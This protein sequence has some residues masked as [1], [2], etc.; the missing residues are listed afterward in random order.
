MNAATQTLKREIPNVG[1]GVSTGILLYLLLF[2][3]TGSIAAANWSDDLGTLTFAAAGSVTLA[4]ALAKQKRIPGWLAHLC[5]LLL[6]LPAIFYL[7]M[8]TLP[9]ALTEEEKAI[10][11]GERV[12]VWLS[13]VALG[14]SATDNLIFVLQLCWTMWLIAHF[15]GWSI[16]RRHQVWGALV[17]TG[18]A[19]VVNLFYSAPQSG[20]YIALYILC[21]L[22][23]LVRLNLQ[24]LEIDW[25][26]GAVGYSSDISFDFLWNGAIITLILLAVVWVIPAGPPSPAWLEFLEP[27]QSSW[28]GFEEQFNRMF[29]GLRGGGRSTAGGFFSNTLTMGGPI[30]LPQQ[31]VM[32]VQTLYAR[33]WR[34]NV[35]DKYNGTGWVNTSVDLLNLAAN[36]ARL[37]SRRDFLRAEV[38]QT[39]KLLASDLPTLFAQSQPIR[40]DLPVEV[41]YTRIDESDQPFVT[42]EVTAVRAR[43]LVR[44]GTVY[45][46]VSVI[47]VADEESLR[48]DSLDYPHW[49]TSTYLQ[50]PDT[51][52]TRVRE[53]AQSLTISY[54]NP[55]DKAVALEK[56]VR[57][58]IKYNEQVSAP[59]PDQDGVDYTL[60]ERREG[61]CNYYASSLAV[62]A[63]AV[64]IPARVVS[65]YSLGDYDNGTFHIFETNAHSWVEIYFPSYGWIEFEPT[66]NKPEFERPKRQTSSAPVEP[67]LEDAASEA[68]RRQAREKELEDE[69]IGNFDPGAFRFDFWNSPNAAAIIGGGIA[70]LIAL[71]TL[72]INI[73]KEIRRNARLAPAARVYERML[74]RARWLGLREEK[75]ATPLERACVINA[76]LPNAHIETERIAA[77]YTRERFG[78]H[79]LDEAERAELA[80]DWRTW[81]GEWL[82]GVRARIIERIVA[83]FRALTENAR[84]FKRRW[85][86]MG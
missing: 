67:E 2:S 52:P 18:V 76:T 9:S 20:L 77:S 30:N 33:Y 44:A 79:T 8:T 66:A 85:E 73:V 29:G 28:Q 57:N 65:G 3:V 32:N 5:S 21:A 78:A 54:T 17:P 12:T 50:L 15:A 47:S 80:N 14:G 40:F 22:L 4:I 74:N 81:R 55:Y 58:T 84:R 41:R 13:R 19:I 71:I 43:R 75:Y 48:T 26:R 37:D 35:Y 45:N 36:E 16:Y 61:Y 34:A 56:Y 51:L 6:S 63:R 53:L 49:I 24:S 83:P 31:P 64:G 70:G 69:D 11:L 7:G 25:R 23:L 68:R 60:F 1:E 72:T 82:R 27:I 10:A 42:Y 46:V 59:P 39:V 62:L 38:T 86:R